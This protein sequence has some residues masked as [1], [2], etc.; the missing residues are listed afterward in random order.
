MPTVAL[1]TSLN[2]THTGI[3]DPA[4]GAALAGSLNFSLNFPLFTGYNTTYRTRAALAQVE[5]RLA[6][7]ERLNQQVAL[8]VWK[9]YQGLVTG[10]QAVTS[11]ADLV[12]SA[13]ESARVSLGRYKAGVGTI[14]EL[15]AAQTALAN[16]R[17]QNIQ[18]LYNWHIAKAVLAQAMGQLDFAAIEAAAPAKTIL[19]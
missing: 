4:N 7:R 11:S 19:N 6:Q 10:T 1:T 3:A 9:A 12:A 2:R 18:A 14:L 13:G 8:D 16:A 17:L 5:T 15:L